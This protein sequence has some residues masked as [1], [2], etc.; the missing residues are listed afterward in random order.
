M[1]NTEL[2]ILGLVAEAPRHGY[3]IERLIEQRGMRNWTEV[4]FSSIYYVLGKLEQR[5]WIASRTE[6]AEGRGPARKVFEIQPTGRDAWYQ[7]TLEALT[8]PGQPNSSFLLGLAGLPGIRS[9]DAV[10]ALRQYRRGILAR[11]NEVDEA[12]QRAGTLPFVLEG[13]FEYSV[14]LLQTELDWLDR[15]IPRLENVAANDDD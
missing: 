5:G 7:A 10:V 1:T 13:M 2:A 15:Y 11:K 3:E 8:G 9:A 4:G 12:W 6:P 14:N